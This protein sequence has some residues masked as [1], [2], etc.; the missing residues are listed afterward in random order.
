MPS[1]GLKYTA[2][3]ARL[4]Q[5]GLTDGQ[6]AEQLSVCK[7]IVTRNLHK[8]RT[9][10][11]IARLLAETGLYSLRQ[12]FASSEVVWR[13]IEQERLK[14]L[15]GK[16]TL[17]AE[18]IGTLVRVQEKSMQLAKAL[19]GKSFR[20]EELADRRDN[21]DDYSDEEKR[22]MEFIARCDAKR[23]LQEIESRGGTVD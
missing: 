18:N 14:L 16:S 6:I 5:Q 9:Q 10:Q 2:E 7:S 22:A 12:V 4:R 1:K 15:E 3:I 21:G 8:A 19:L 13:W 11:R 23:A 17:T 20:P